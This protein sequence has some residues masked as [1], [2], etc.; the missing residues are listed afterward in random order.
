MH[1]KNEINYQNTYTLECESSFKT[2]DSHYDH[3]QFIMTQ[4]S[5]LP[6]TNT[7]NSPTR[8]YDKMVVPIT[9]KSIDQ[10]FCLAEIVPPIDV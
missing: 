6:Q 7:D 10:R 5:F 3:N 1:F 8:N 2:A 9:G 4:D